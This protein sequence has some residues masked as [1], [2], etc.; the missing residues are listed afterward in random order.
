MKPGDPS[1]CVGEVWHR[2]DVPIVHE[3]RHR[4]Q[5]AWFD[6]DRPGELTRHHP[7]WSHRRPAPVRFRRRDYGRTSEGSLTEQARD[8]AATVLGVRP[9]GPVRMLTQLRRWGWLFN[10]ITVYV[11]WAGGDDP[12]AIVLEVTNTPWKE[13]HHYAA[14][15]SPDP[16]RGRF[17][18]RFPKSL[19]VSPFLDEDHEYVLALAE[20]AS[21][22]ALSIDVVA[23]DGF[24]HLS[25]ALAVE[26][27]PATRPALGRALWSA[28]WS[29][30]R[31]S[32]GIHHQAWR[33]W[34]RGVAVVA[35]PRKRSARAVSE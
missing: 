2:R 10:P 32:L 9:D 1:V 13:R 11:A 23:G 31:V 21:T 3:F 7:L 8:A 29:T 34:R 14:R 30:H 35:H 4:V 12:A 27:R 24:R 15:L 17:V 26:R 22:I 20:R 6:P 5:Y 33:L 18:A 25:T 28:P 16:E 19:H